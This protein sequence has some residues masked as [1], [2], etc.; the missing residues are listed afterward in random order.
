MGGGGGGRAR[1]ARRS[2]TEICS[3][4]ELCAGA[5][6]RRPCGGRRLSPAA[7]C[8]TT[9]PAR[10]P[11]RLTRGHEHKHVLP[12][13]RG[14]NDS[15]LAAPEGADAKVL[16]VALAQLLV[17]GEAALPAP[18]AAAVHRDALQLLDVDSCG[19]GGGPSL[20]ALG[21]CSSLREL[22]PQQPQA[23]HSSG[24]RGR[25]FQLRSAHSSRQGQAAGS[26]GGGPP[27]AA[28]RRLGS[29]AL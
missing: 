7:P 20:Q 12:G 26:D 19:G 24:I 4:L 25:G 6:A 10:L 21:Q 27:G 13:Q 17:P 29:G 3:T 18:V 14:V 8:P 16:P 22:V 2:C 5:R 1:A 11:A 9:P 28:V 23:P 15:L